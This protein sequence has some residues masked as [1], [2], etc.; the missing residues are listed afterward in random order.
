MK[1]NWK[2]R[3]KNKTTLTALIACIAAF[4]YQLLSIFGITVPISENQFM[5]GAGIVINLLGTLGVL[6]D[7]T[8]EGTNDSLKALTYNRPN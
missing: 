1:I 4:V 3:L 6:V 8:T 2:L 7:P 5:Q